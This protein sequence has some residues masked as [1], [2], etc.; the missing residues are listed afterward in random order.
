MTYR[1]PL[2]FLDRDSLCAARAQVAMRPVQDFD[3]QMS[4]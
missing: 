1:S 2:V 3:S 4:H